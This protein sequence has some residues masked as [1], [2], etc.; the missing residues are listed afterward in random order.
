MLRRIAA[1][2]VLAFAV[3][4]LA[5]KALAQP[6]TAAKEPTFRTISDALETSFETKD[7]Q[8]KVKFRDFLEIFGMKLGGKAPIVVDREAFQVELGADAPDPL[9]EEVA[10]PRVPT[11]LKGERALRIV[12]G[13]LGKG[14]ATYLIRNGLI[15]I[16]T[17][18]AAAPE[19]LLGYPITAR[20]E[21]KP[22]D[23]AIES[24]CEMSGATIIIDTRVGDKS[25]TPVSATFRNSIALD[26]AVRLLAEMADLQVDVQENVLFI[27]SKP[28]PGGQKEKVDLEL[29]NRRLDLAVKD[30]ARWSGQSILLDP[31][32]IPG[33]TP[34]M[35]PWGGKPKRLEAAA[36]AGP[37]NP[38]PVSIHSPLPGKIQEIARGLKPGSK[39]DEGQTL[40]V[41]FDADLA[42]Q[43]RELQTAMQAAQR[44]L[45]SEGGITSPA[46]VLNS[47][48]LKRLQARV[49]AD[50]ARPGYFT[51]AAPR[52]GTILSA[53]FREKLQNKSV[54]PG[55]SLIQIG[56]PPG[57][58]TGELRDIRI[59]AAFKPNVSAKAAAE[60]IARQA[61]LTVIEMDNLLYIT[62]PF[63][64]MGMFGGGKLPQ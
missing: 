20:F 41:L 37:V 31:M 3:S 51:I 61:N 44:K 62:H 43:V 15:E 63:M 18:K 46:I 27:T 21:K 40:L 55:E 24:L 2:A 60:V 34:I 7:L 14:T 19:T 59:T 36:S 22:L 56:M 45:K 53:D 6:K 58:P 26:G 25:R 48:S 29:K 42:Q 9:E 4:F 10:L 16:T 39:V 47:E 1:I 49:N 32:F 33:P 52:A 30:L 38:K 13:Q 35:A 23:E 64:G 5:N 17:A 57:D 8:E 12:L 54:K 50:L 11:R 28:K